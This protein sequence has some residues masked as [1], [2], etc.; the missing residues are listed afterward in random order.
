[1]IELIQIPW[2]PFCLVQKRILEYARAK[3]KTREVPSGDRSLVWKLTRGRYYQVPVLKDGTTVLFETD[4]NSQI[5]AKYL[6][7]RF[8]LGLFPEHW[9]GV[10]TI[11]SRH[12]ENE[13]EA[14]TFKLNDI[15]WSE[16]VAPAEQLN[17][18]RFKERKFGR[19]CLDRWRAEQS[20][21]LA[22]L[23]IALAPF[24]QMLADKPFLLGDHPLF[25]DFDLWGMLAN[26][27]YS[28]H[29]QFPSECPKLLEWRQR[30]TEAHAS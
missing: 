18:I 4:E 15:F 24:E 16:L 28:G 26:F 21:L 19:G 2:S 29:Y 8:K 12:I 27:L 6:D 17:F 23:A 5:I 11:L 25:V 20:Q 7:G 10:Q 30:L 9:R 14:I 3:F 1:M 13:V 22:Q